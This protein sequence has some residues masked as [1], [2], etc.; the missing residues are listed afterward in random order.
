MLHGR[1]VG[2]HLD[3]WSCVL[4]RPLGYLIFSLM[5]LIRDPIY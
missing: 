4:G 2:S 1:K 5:V 3:L